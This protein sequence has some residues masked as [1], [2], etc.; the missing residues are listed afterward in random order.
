MTNPLTHRQKREAALREI[1]RLSELRIE[2]MERGDQAA[3]Q[4]LTAR[5]RSLS[6]RVTKRELK[7]LERYLEALKRLLPNG[8][9]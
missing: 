1:D 5:L 9:K 8:A 2:A 6:P 7:A 3:F 4:A